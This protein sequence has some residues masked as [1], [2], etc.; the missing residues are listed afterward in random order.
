VDVDGDGWM[1]ILVANDTV[2]KFFFHNR[3]AAKDGG[4]LFE[5]A[6]EVFGLAYDRNG[7]ATGAMGVDSAYHRNDP[8]LA[9]AIGNF[10]NEMASLFVTTEGRAPFVDEAVLEGL[11]PA[12]RIPLTFGL[13]FFDY[14]LDGRLDL[15]LAN[16]HLEHEIQKVQQ[17]QTYAQPPSL[18]WNCGEGCRGR[19]TPVT[20][21]GDLA[22]PLV[23]RGVSFADIDS[24]GDLD[25]LITQNGRRPA[26]LRNDQETVHRWL[27]VKL[28]GLPPNTDAIGARLE[29]TA[30]GIT[31]YREVMPTRG[32]MSQVEL[33]VTFGLGDA[34]Q[35]ERLRIL[36]PDG[37]DQEL[38]PE[39]VDTTLVVKQGA[40]NT[41]DSL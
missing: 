29:L 4:P 19:Y 35:V 13:L 20:D 31:R 25:V 10:A 23:G 2:R 6:G 34:D 18:F 8:N 7:N 33:P 30:G 37:S 1:D 28:E 39:A 22:R 41:R 5:E 17:S 12:S 16:G 21:A 11:G 40:A 32:Y 9:F 3:G 36:W 27:R 26:L 15:L 38:A 24:D 14:D